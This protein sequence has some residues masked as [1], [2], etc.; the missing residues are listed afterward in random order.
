MAR[1][2]PSRGHRLPVEP[3][4]C[5]QVKRGR[6]PPAPLLHGRRH[7]AEGPHSRRDTAPCGTPHTR[8]ARA[9]QEFLRGFEV[10]A[11]PVYCN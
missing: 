7:E 3:E 2:G 4:Q 5:G 8:T 6:L 1:P 9:T 10:I 11:S